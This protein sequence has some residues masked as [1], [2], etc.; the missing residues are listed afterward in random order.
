MMRI[1]RFT[2]AAAAAVAIVPMVAGG[3]FAS[4]PGNDKPGGA[5]AL[6]LSKAF[7]EDTTQATTGGLDANANERCGAPFTNASVWF[8]Y[9]AP[10]DNGFIVDASASDYGVGLMI[11]HGVPSPGSFFGC[12]PTMVA[13][14]HAQAGK[15]YTIMAFSD[16]ARIGGHL[17]LTL[18]P[19]P[20]APTI[21]VTI[22]PTGIAYPSGNARVSGTYTCANADGL[23]GN[24]VLTLVWRRLKISGFFGIRELGAC[25][26][27]PHD[28]TKVVTSD[29]G[30]Y[31]AGAAA[32]EIRSDACG[33]LQCTRAKAAQDVTLSAAAQPSGG[34]AVSVHQS[35]AG[36]ASHA[37]TVWQQSLA[38]AAKRAALT[39]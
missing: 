35:S 21:A 11:F 36:T 13:A 1:A 16:T 38:S 4:P 26:G 30:L 7:N 19:A 34:T 18:E 25:D 17:S 28:W 6:T 39:R 14:R 32:V 29:N 2:L 10:D 5:I 27:Q 33:L 12:G 20:P 9:T 3:A 8:T 15:T 24:G 22:D 37:K 23:F 31:G